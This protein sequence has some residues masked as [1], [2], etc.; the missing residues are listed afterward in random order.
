MIRF[1][2]AKNKHTKRLSQTTN[3][4][5]LGI[6]LLIMHSRKAKINYRRDI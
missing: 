5:K 4:N 2:L 3:K 6:D 1:L